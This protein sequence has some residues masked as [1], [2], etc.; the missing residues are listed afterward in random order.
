M[1]MLCGLDDVDTESSGQKVS[2]MYALQLAGA[3]CALSL[4]FPI[5]IQ[6]CNLIYI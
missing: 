4:H 1:K 2:I 5:C 3:L 6:V